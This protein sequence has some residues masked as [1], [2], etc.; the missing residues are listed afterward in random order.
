[1]IYVGKQS[2]FHTRS[3]DEIHE[4]LLQFAESGKT[5][6]RLKVGTIAHKNSAVHMSTFFSEGGESFLDTL[7]Q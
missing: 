1:M 5:I 4:L 3:Q 2:G 7:Q 6:L